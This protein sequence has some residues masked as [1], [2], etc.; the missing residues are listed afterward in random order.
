MS[1]EICVRQEVIAPCMNDQRPPR[2]APSTVDSIV[3]HL[4]DSWVCRIDKT[5]FQ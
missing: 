1:V 3:L 4:I 2:D 5:D